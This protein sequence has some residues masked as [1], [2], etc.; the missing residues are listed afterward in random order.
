MPQPTR[1]VLVTRDHAGE[2][3]FSGFGAADNNA[4]AD[5]FIDASKLPEDTIKAGALAP[6]NYVPVHK[7]VIAAPWHAPPLMFHV[8][9]ADHM[10]REW[11]AL[12][13]TWGQG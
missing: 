10:A 8:L 11:L 13:S 12:S 5:C 2:R 1:D 9:P 4:Y 6:V 7:H 3:E